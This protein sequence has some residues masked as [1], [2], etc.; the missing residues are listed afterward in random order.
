MKK[1]IKLLS[2]LLGII[3]ALTPILSLTVS[4]SDAANGQTS[5][6]NEEYAS[7]R[8]DLVITEIFT[9]KGE[10]PDYQFIE[11]K[12]VSG[13]EVDLADYKLQRIMSGS[14]IIEPRTTLVLSLKLKANRHSSLRIAISEAEAKLGAG[15]VAVLFLNWNS[16]SA[17]EISDHFGSTTKVI[18]VT[19]AE[20]AR[21]VNAPNHKTNSNGFL[22]TSN[23]TCIISLVETTTDATVNYEAAACNA[24]LNTF[25]GE[26]GTYSHNYYGWVDQNAVANLLIDKPESE[27]AN[28][29]GG[30]DFTVGDYSN[31]VTNKLH[32]TGYNVDLS[33]GVIKYV[34]KD[35]SGADALTLHFISDGTDATPTPGTLNVG[36]FETLPAVETF[37]KQVK[38]VGDT[39]SVRFTAS[40][41][42]DALEAA[43][44]IGFEIVANYT[45]ADGTTGTKNITKNCTTVY[46]S[47]YGKGED[48]SGIFTN[49]DLDKG[50]DY[51]FSVTITN[52]LIETYEE[53]TFTVTP[54]I[55]YEIDSNEVTV[56]AESA[57][58]TYDDGAVVENA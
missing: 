50:H 25:G 43:K 44:N 46:A 4:A 36:Q 56:K 7:I 8:G 2:V 34:N 37:G 5:T 45:L 58:A 17:T 27:P 38:I 30:K 51:F 1:T 54:Y 15:E 55:T 22:P 26:D 13:K 28:I 24:V 6:Y 42:A 35:A 49:A 41:D 57:P 9:G 19:V 33:S 21:A 3:L 12:N 14:S 23:E 32:P 52:I 16:N 11:V 40:L 18:T 53:I 47:I 10:N 31:F 20:N 29:I 39:Y 48:G